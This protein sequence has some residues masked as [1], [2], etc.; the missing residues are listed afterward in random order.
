MSENEM[1][2]GI[3][4]DTSKAK[5]E[6]NEV[7]S[8]KKV[9]DAGL[10]QTKQNARDTMQVSFAVVRS[11]YQLLKG[12]LKAAG[13]TVDGITNAVIMSTLNV[14]Q[15]LYTIGTAYTTAGAVNPMMMAVGIATLVQ[16]GLVINA[17][18]NQEQQ[19]KETMR[20]I[21]ITNDIMGG[22]VG[23]IGAIHY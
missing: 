11:S 21:E 13:V 6:L 19:S 20:Q 3:I 9:A 4:L 5:A 15:Q 8:Q 2:V 18:I 7:E 16:S 17:A 22:I 23:M 1:N 10:E 14:G 12:I